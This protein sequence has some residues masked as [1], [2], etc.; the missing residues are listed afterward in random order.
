V[1]NIVHRLEFLK[2]VIRAKDYEEAQKFFN[3]L[4]ENL[5]KNGDD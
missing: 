4:R 1:E 5:G 2:H 3:K